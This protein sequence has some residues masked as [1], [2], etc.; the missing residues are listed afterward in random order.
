MEFVR[1]YLLQSN[2]L[3][4]YCLYT[5]RTTYVQQR[6]NPFDRQVNVPVAAIDGDAEPTS[7]WTRFM[8]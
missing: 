2:Q 7:F 3:I 6:F 1:I 4:A 5:D 8:K